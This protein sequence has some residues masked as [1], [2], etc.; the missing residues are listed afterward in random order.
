MDFNIVFTDENKDDALK[1]ARSLKNWLQDTEIEDLE[2]SL[3]RKELQEDDA[4]AG[5]VEG[6]LA[7]T[8]AAPSVV[9]LAKAL[10]VW[11]KEKTKQ[12]SG[13]V[14]MKIK[15]GDIEIEIDTENAGKSEEDIIETL[16]KTL[17]DK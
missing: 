7:V 8:L 9:I 6:I 2:L 15:K 11:I 12:K 3:K 13:K 14:K 1:Q 5:V 17:K 4:A 10:H 16:T